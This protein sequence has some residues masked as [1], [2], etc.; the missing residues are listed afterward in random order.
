QLIGYVHE[1]ELTGE[2]R[3]LDAAAGIFAA[4]VPGRMYAHGGTGESELWG[5]A[6]TVAGDIGN[7]NAETCVAYNLI[8][9]ARLLF[10]HTLDPT[11]TTYVEHAVLNQILGA[12]KAA[13]S[14]VSPEVTYI[15]PVHPGARREF[16][17]IGTCGG[18]TGL[19]NHVK[20]GEGLFSRAPGQVW[21]HH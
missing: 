6:D 3:Y 18:G 8:K 5:P 21:I 11:Y 13:D 14:D 4:I 16:N 7:R 15:F 1:Y 9:L 17:N 20:Y 10:A 19:E 12:R 2:R